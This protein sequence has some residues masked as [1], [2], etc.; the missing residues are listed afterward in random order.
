[1]KGRIALLERFAQKFAAPECYSESRFDCRQI[2]LPA[3]TPQYWNNVKARFTR[4]VED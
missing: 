4:D 2:R 3:A 1:M